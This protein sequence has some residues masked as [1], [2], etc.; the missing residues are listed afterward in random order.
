MKLKMQ[1][2]QSAALAAAVISASG[3]IAHSQAPLSA[4]PLTPAAAERQAAPVT[5]EEVQAAGAPYLSWRQ[6]NNEV[7]I[8]RSLV[9]KQNPLLDRQ[10]LQTATAAS[11]GNSPGRGPMSAKPLAAGAPSIHKVYP[12]DWELGD[13]NVIATSVYGSLNLDGDRNG[14]NAAVSA[15]LDGFLFGHGARLV[16]AT[17]GY[18]AF[19]LGNPNANH[20]RGQIALSLLG[21]TVYS[22]NF[23]GAFTW[24]ETTPPLS[25][26]WGVT[27]RFMIGPI[28][29]SAKIGARGTAS[30]G[31]GVRVDAVPSA[32][33]IFTPSVQASAYA[34]LAVDVVVARIGVGANLCLARFQLPMHAA[35]AYAPHGPIPGLS[36][37][38]DQGDSFTF[39]SG[40]L[41]LFADVNVWF[42]HKHFETHIFDW[43]GISE[44]R[45]LAQE[46]GWVPLQ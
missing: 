41:Y 7:Y 11:G 25:L 13:R 16:S 15:S 3:G 42:V 9:V 37:Y 19:P 18:Q 39:L 22:R 35:F 20:A 21:N 12:F 30:L 10:A 38:A 31:F 45:M 1:L 14:M 6:G 40:Y 26:D 34:E 28:P 32:N 27:T 2:K 23:E 17:G 33:L 46:G 29:V 43:G 24:Q 36:F 5:P 8:D 4:P 44:N